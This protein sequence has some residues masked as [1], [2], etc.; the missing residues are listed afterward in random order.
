M[1]GGLPLIISSWRQ[2]PWGSRAVIFLQ[3]NPWGHSLYVTASLTR[4]WVCL[5]WICFAFVKSTDPTYSICLHVYGECL[6][7]SGSGQSDKTDNLEWRT[8]HGLSDVSLRAEP[9]SYVSLAAVYWTHSAS[10]KLPF[11]L[12]AMTFSGLWTLA[13]IL[14]H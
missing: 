11:A 5:L 13:A 12:N 2:A 7:F 8:S 1:T 6:F 3:L 4:R 10:S 14:L 9:H